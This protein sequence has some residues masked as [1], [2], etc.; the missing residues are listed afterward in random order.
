MSLWIDLTLSSFSSELKN[1]Q[2]TSS[3]GAACVNAAFLFLAF[4]SVIT[5]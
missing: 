5:N 2:E 4:Y 1:K 3:F